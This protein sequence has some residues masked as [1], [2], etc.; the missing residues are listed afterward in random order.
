VSYGLGRGGLG[1]SEFEC[2]QVKDPA[3][4]KKKCRWGS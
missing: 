3:A 1:A 2:Y 4:N